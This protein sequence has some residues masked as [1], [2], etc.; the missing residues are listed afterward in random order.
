MQFESISC[1]NLSDLWPHVGGLFFSHLCCRYHRSKGGPW[2][3]GGI[4]YLFVRSYNDIT[5]TYSWWIMMTGIIVSQQNAACSYVA[6]RPCCAAQDGNTAPLKSGCPERNSL[7]AANLTELFQKNRLMASCKARRTEHGAANVAHH[8]TFQHGAYVPCHPP[9]S[10]LS[11]EIQSG[12]GIANDAKPCETSGRLPWAFEHDLFSQSLHLSFFGLHVWC[13]LPV[14]CCRSLQC[15]ASG[16]VLH[17][18]TTSRSLSMYPRPKLFQETAVLT[19]CISSCCLFVRLRSAQQSNILGSF[20][21]W[22]S[23]LNKVSS[24]VQS[25]RGSGDICVD[26]CG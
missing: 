21:S 1:M 20:S 8:A 3:L 9:S 17:T 26:L 14:I 4:H 5:Y 18:D 22:H 19:M 24:A 11:C 7:S 10:L 23:F 15:L 6:S 13:C 25:M 12:D 2:F 16:F